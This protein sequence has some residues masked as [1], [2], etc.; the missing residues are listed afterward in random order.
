[1]RHLGLVDLPFMSNTLILWEQLMVSQQWRESK[2]KEKQWRWA[3]D[4]EVNTTFN[5]GI[6]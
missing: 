2:N 3:L 6:L 4:T 1:M 5:K